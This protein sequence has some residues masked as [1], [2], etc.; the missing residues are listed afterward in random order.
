MKPL[1]RKLE[2]AR[3]RIATA[4]I[5]PATTAAILAARPICRQYKTQ[6]TGGV[7]FAVSVCAI[8]AVM[9]AVILGL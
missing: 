7:A 5:N 9:V 8:G 6:Q 2:A 3:R 4:K 1:E